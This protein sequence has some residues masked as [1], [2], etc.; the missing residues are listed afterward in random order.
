ME[1]NQKELTTF[2][3]EKRLYIKRNRQKEWVPKYLEPSTSVDV[4]V[5]GSKN[6]H[7]RLSLCRM[8]L[9]EAFLKRGFSRKEAGE[10][11]A[12]LKPFWLRVHKIELKDIAFVV[13]ITGKTES[14]DLITA[15]DYD[16]LI[17]DVKHFKPIERGND[18]VVINFKRILKAVDGA[19]VE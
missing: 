19:L 2:Q 18:I 14:P 13:L 17:S 3:I 9:F 11:V 1:K 5:P 7:D 4:D 6:T 16:E 8:L 12:Q 15:R 10:R